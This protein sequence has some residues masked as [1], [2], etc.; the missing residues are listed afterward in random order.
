M[1]RLDHR[2]TEARECGIHRGTKRGPILKMND[3]WDEEAHRLS[4]G[5][6]EWR[7]L[8][9][10]IKPPAQGGVGPRVG[11]EG[12]SSRQAKNGLVDGK[13]VIGMTTSIHFPCQ[14]T[15]V[16]RRPARDVG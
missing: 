13:K 12:S 3:I 16:S 6:A 10:E 5:A 14:F 9:M 8:D 7:M 2:D 4:E 15:Q 11:M 1:D